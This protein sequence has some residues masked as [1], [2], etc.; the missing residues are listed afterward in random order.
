MSTRRYGRHSV[1][2]SNEDKTFFPESGLTKGD[3]IDYYEQIAEYILPLVKD[4][5]LNL[6]RC[7]DGI[8]RKGFIQQ[9]RPDY[10]PGWIKEVTVEK[11]GGRVTHALA[12]KTAD[13]V[14]LADQGVLTFHIWQSRKDKLH[15]P[16]RMIYDL[17]PPHGEFS[18]VRQAALDIRV[19]MEEL[20]L[21]PFVS[22]TGS[23]GLH[24]TVP[25]RRDS[26]F[27]T[28]RSFARD[29]AD[30]LASQKNDDYTLE[31]RKNKR[32]G[33][34]LL[35]TVRNA[36]GQT[37]AAPYSIRARPGAPVATPLDWEEVK[38]ST[39][40]PQ[41]YMIQNI[42]RRLSQKDDPWKDFARS[43][44]SIKEARKKLDAMRKEN[45]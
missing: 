44:E 39:L 16:D 29:V 8:R 15:S 21:S 20:G 1:Q 36:Y 2:I 24:V 38:R 23:S 22:T 7:P 37:V 11:E 42:F 35:D 13:L 6:E 45:E 14:Y 18:L 30:H 34:V 43:A 12:S 17:D 40:D 3:V 31:I 9:D 25:I 32:K 41:Q 26:N 27:D 19:I 28:V 33:R 4:R 5:P 10:F